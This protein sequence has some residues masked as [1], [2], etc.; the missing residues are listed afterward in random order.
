LAC[1]AHPDDE[2]FGSGGTLARYAA[3]G[4][5]VVLVCA[6]RGE[7]GQISDASLAT[8]ETL[9][10]VREQEM[11]CAA[12]TLGIH[13]LV[14]LDQRD[15][16][17]AGTPENAHPDAYVN[18]PEDKV[19]GVLAGII[20][21]ERP[22]VVMTFDPNGAYGHPDHVA[23]HRHTIAAL[24]AASDP[25]CYPERGPAW[26]AA[27]LVYPVFP[28]S[29]FQ[30]MREIY[31][32]YA[33]DASEIERFEEHAGWPDEQVHVVIDV[34]GQI[35]AKWAAFACHRTQFGTDNFLQRVPRAALSGIMGREHFA[36]GSPTPAPDAAL[37]DLF[38]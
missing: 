11:R 32:A 10:R 5:R 29:G 21:R 23:I 28:R 17:M 34:S 15:S 31:L 13:E 19:V 25:S 18:A 7:V 33:E 22:Q 2:V 12:R 3:D 35:A 38:G 20:R 14:F 24:H 1:F 9:G 26:Q 8:P 16:G 4:V 6:T 30:R 37:S 36:L 27:R